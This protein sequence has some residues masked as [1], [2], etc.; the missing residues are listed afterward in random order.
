M[1]RLPRVTVLSLI[2][3]VETCPATVNSPLLSS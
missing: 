1:V 2:E 3:L